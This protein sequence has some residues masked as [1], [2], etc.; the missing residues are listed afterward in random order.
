MAKGRRNNKYLLNIYSK[1]SIVNTTLAEKKIS[2]LSTYFVA[3]MVK[4]ASR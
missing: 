3:H 2:A 4:Q 1:Q